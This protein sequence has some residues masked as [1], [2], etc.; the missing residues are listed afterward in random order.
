MK[1]ISYI[2]LIIVNIV[3]LYGVIWI[4]Y[5]I[6]QF[7]QQHNKS[8]ERIK[9]NEEVPY[10]NYDTTWD[11]ELPLKKP[12]KLIEINNYTLCKEYEYLSV[13]GCQPSN[14]YQSENINTIN[15][16][17]STKQNITVRKKAKIILIIDDIGVNIFQSLLAIS[18]NKNVILSF[19]PYSSKLTSLL[20]AAI[21][22]KHSIM[23]HLP[24]QPINPNLDPGPDVLKIS[25]NTKQTKDILN[26]SF[27][28]FDTFIP[29]IVAV[30]NHMGSRFM[31]DKSSLLKVLSFLKRKNI[32]FL[33]SLTG[34]NSKTKALAS[35][36]NIPYLIRDIFLDTKPDESYISHQ[37]NL[38]IRLAQHQG[39]AVV[40]AHPYPATLKLI[41]LLIKKA[42]NS[43]V[44]L[45]SLKDNIKQLAKHNS[46]SFN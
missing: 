25:H 1:R 21:N 22:A 41:P 2:L 5:N 17:R 36:L 6:H 34:P 24:M 37:W 28:K 20:Q 44:S 32:Y 43:G 38:A 31:Q 23:L 19:L 46:S 27:K 33:D 3:A 15:K 29:N 13:N 10:N 30:N 9:L 35:Q 42:K 14:G 11:Y 18:L 4:I 16:L 45:A 40:I 12:S 8:T 7:K 39:I 26:M